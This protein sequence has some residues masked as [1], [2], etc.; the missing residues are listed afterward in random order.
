L[1]GSRRFDHIYTWK[2]EDGLLRL[3]GRPLP[4]WTGD[5][6]AYYGE[7]L[8]VHIK[9]LSR[10]LSEGSVPLF[11]L[12]KP[13]RRVFILRRRAGKRPIGGQ[14]VEDQKFVRRAAVEC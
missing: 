8:E 13:V 9:G 10:K 1:R 2:H 3:K 4:G 5:V 12:A 14:G 7:Q 6:A 11:S